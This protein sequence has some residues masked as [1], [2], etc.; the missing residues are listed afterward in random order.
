MQYVISEQ[1]GGTL[2]RDYLQRHLGLSHRLITRLKQTPDGILLNGR[3][4]TVRATLQPSDTLTLATE[5]TRHTLSGV[6]P[7]GSMPPVL[8][9]D[10]H[11]LVCNKPG[12]M[13]THPSHGHFDDTLANACAAYML[14][15]TGRVGVFRPVNRLDRQTS[16]IVLIAKHQLA[17]GRL[18]EDMRN[19][20]IQ[21]S[22]LAIVEGIP[23]PPQGRIDAPIRRAQQSIIERV[24]CRADEPGAHKA[25][26]EY[27]TLVHWPLPDGQVRS[28]ARACPLTGRTHQLRVHF[29]H[30]GT[31]IAGDAL[32]GDPSISPLPPR[33]CLHAHTLCFFHPI[34]RQEM[35]LSAPM[36]DDMLCYIPDAVRA[37]LPV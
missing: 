1:H 22:Y 11:I 34:S 2:V 17:A 19:G 10:D 8:Y 25:I 37:A 21:K 23:V 12:H 13:P 7:S 18:S 15:R 4:V 5:D 36:P 29:S 14:E 26:T 16:G 9:E 33:Q 27:L 35:R 20:R 31:P 28:L 6:V 32:Y 24:V 30:I 3:P